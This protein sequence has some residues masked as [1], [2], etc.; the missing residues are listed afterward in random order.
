M[1]KLNK[2]DKISIKKASKYVRPARN[3]YHF[4]E[5]YNKEDEK[6]NKNNMSYN[7]YK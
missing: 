6:L 3:K 4:P 2:N 5:N 7:H 1:S